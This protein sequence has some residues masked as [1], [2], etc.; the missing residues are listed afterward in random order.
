MQTLK[1]AQPGLKVQQRANLKGVIAHLKIATR[2]K[3]RAT[4][5]KRKGVVHRHQVSAATCR[6]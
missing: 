3:V 2:R 5:C 1:V 4:R 6:A